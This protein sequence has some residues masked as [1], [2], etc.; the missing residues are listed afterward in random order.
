MSTGNYRELTAED[1][2]KVLKV[3]S[4]TIRNMIAKKEIRGKK[5]EKVVYKQA[6]SAFE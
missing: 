4:R 6:N 2:A 5:V 1:A 3:H